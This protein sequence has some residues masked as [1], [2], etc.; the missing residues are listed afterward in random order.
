[1]KFMLML[2][3]RIVVIV[4]RAHH[5]HA[6]RTKLHNF[7][8]PIVACTYYTYYSKKNIGMYTLR[9]FSLLIFDNSKKPSARRRFTS[10]V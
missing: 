1:M 10:M 2:A 5:T 4:I 7:R 3:G 9:N 6:V 8:L